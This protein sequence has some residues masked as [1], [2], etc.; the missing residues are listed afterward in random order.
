MM[1]TTLLG[2]LAM[3][4]LSACAIEESSAGTLPPLA[5]TVDVVVPPSTSPT[6]TG[7]VDGWYARFGA[8]V[9]QHRT[10]IAAVRD[11]LVAE[12]DQ[13]RRIVICTAGTSIDSP[14]FDEAHRAPGAQPDW[15]R[16]VDLTR[17][18]VASCAGGAVEKV[19]E[20]L[21]SLDDALARFDAWCSTQP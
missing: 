8:A 3:G 16:A 21:P 13:A 14:A 6:T 9:R 15:V 7:P 19:D 5:D 4:A 17:W 18:M 1:R 2:L 11:G 10:A 12:R 20:I